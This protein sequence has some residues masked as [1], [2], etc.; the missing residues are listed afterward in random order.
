MSQ[1]PCFS[2]AASQPCR[3]RQF[4]TDLPFAI[5]LLLL[6][7]SLNAELR[8]EYEIEK[9][10]RKKLQEVEDAHFLNEAINAAV[11]D[12]ALVGYNEDDKDEKQ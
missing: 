11:Q 10:V 5:L 7:Y 3:L 6:V 8:K 12:E 1:R 9:E 4:L 2:A